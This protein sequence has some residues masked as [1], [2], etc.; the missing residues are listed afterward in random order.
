VYKRS[1]C[2]VSGFSAYKYENAP[3]VY[4]LYFTSSFGHPFFF[5]PF[6]VSYLFCVSG[7]LFTRAA[8]YDVT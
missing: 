4:S 5:S 1:R 2:A 7:L 3:F 6:S 8:P